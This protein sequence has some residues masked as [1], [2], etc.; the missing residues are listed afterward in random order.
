MRLRET[1]T[2]LPRWAR[3]VLA[4]YVVGF[5]DG[6]GDHIRWMLHGGIHA[7]AA[8]YPQVPI[9]V[10]FVGLV[11]LDPLAAVLAGLA[12]REGV[13]LACA[14]MA[15][16]VIANW[17]GNWTRITSPQGRLFGTVPWL[18]TVFGLFVFGTAIPLTRVIRRDRS[19]GTASPVQA[20]S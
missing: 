2:R 15:A 10:L 13:W 5:A 6:T 1:W 12:R 18:I 19:A 8:A 17:T 4:G 9:Q 7:Y 11:V 14:I 16:D 20:A 3:W